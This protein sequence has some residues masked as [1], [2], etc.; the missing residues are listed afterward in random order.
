[1]PY[2]F[3]LVM[4]VADLVLKS[5]GINILITNK[6]VSILSSLN[7]GIFLQFAKRIRLQNNNFS[8]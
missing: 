7:L 2:W 8:A 6:L 1:M 4:P 5:D 3:K